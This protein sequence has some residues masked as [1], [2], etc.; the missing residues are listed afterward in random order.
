M[1]R[2]ALRSK[3]LLRRISLARW[4]RLPDKYCLKNP[5]AVIVNSARKRAYATVSRKRSPR[6]TRSCNS[7]LPFDAWFSRR[8]G[9]FRGL[10]HVS[11]AAYGLDQLGLI[12]VVDLAPQ[13]PDVDIDDIGET[14]VVHIPHVLDDHGAAQRPALVTHHVFQDAE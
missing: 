1:R 14:V 12:A 2:Y 10:D 8:G 7:N 6:V 4:S 5:L 9:F 13:M 3:K 11:D